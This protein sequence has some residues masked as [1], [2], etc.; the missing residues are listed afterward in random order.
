MSDSRS[1][2]VRTASPVRLPSSPARS[3]RSWSDEENARIVGR[4]LPVR[5]YRRLPGQWAGSAN[6]ARADA[7]ARR[8]RLAH[9]PDRKIHAVE[10]QGLNGLCLALTFDGV[11]QYDHRNVGERHTSGQNVFAEKRA[12]ST[13]REIATFAEVS[14]AAVSYYFGSK[15]DE[16]SFRLNERRLAD[17]EAS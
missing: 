6:K 10:L 15:L 16:L 2:E 3:Y 17:F 12:K 4:W 8:Q 9:L 1:F 5:M 11:S 14:L 13:L 7:S